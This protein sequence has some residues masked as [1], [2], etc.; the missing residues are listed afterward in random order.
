MAQ[1]ELELR[2]PSILEI[3]KKILQALTARWT[4]GEIT[5]EEFVTSAALAVVTSRIR[6]ANIGAD[7]VRRDLE[8][9]LAEPVRIVPPS[10]NRT[11]DFQRLTK[12][13]ET[14]AA[15]VPEG[16]DTQDEAF[17]AILRRVD[18]RLER[19]ARA[20]TAD[21]A[22]DGAQQALTDDRV[23]GWVRDRN[24]AACEL[25][26]WW[27][28]EGRVWPADHLM[29]KHVGCEC[30]P[31]PVTVNYQPRVSPEAQKRSERD[32]RKEIA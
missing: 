30:W 28:R 17:Q 21:A 24:G 9:Q 2:L 8:A 11:A 15:D 18:M 23:Q 19:L 20:E 4:S 10:V 13:L 12:A 31:R 16:A 27:W 22:Q 5:R 7:I 14:I 3:V 6:G 26:D 25:C 32:R 29:P 1:N